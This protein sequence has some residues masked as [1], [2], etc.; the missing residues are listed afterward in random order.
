[1]T[2]D[3]RMTL[4]YSQNTIYLFFALPTPFYFP[5]MQNGSYRGKQVLLSMFIC[6]FQILGTALTLMRFVEITF[7]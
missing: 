4:G 7:K 1:M 6:E 3:S 2:C 5:Y